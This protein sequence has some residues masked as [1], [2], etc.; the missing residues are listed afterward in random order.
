[1]AKRVFLS[2]IAAKYLHQY[3]NF[4]NIHGYRF[5]RFSLFALHLTIV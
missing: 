4:L 5:I 2:T 3:N 1:M